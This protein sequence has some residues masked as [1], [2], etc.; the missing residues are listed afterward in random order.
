M[1]F[2]KF[3]LLQLYFQQTLCTNLFSDI[4]EAK[5]IQENYEIISN[6]KT[7]LAKQYNKNPEDITR[8]EIHS[9]SSR[10]GNWEKILL[11]DRNDSYFNK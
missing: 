8:D 11:L 2:I 4:Q 10:G 5:Q 3:L 1:A 9:S 6:I 7:L